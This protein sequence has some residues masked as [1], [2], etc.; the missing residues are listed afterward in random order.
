[1]SEPTIIEQLLPCPFC[2]ASLSG[3]EHGAFGHEVDSPDCILSYT[4]F[5]AS[6]VERWNTRALARQ[7]VSDDA[8]VERD[9]ICPLCWRPASTHKPSC[10]VTHGDDVGE[11]VEALKAVD[12]A[13]HT[14][15]PEDWERATKLTDAALKSRQAIGERER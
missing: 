13:R 5:D 9:D 14:D 3:L 7:Q 8:V 2:G 15:A 11:L 1:M 10:P 12:L 4:A 6:D